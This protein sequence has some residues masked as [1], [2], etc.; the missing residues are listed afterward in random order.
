MEQNLL[1]YFALSYLFFRPLALP[2]VKTGVLYR[3]PADHLVDE[4]L[5]FVLQTP[6]RHAFV[7][8]QEQLQVVWGIL[9][10]FA[11]IVLAMAFVS[12]I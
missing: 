2:A 11:E 6:E 12:L 8:V 9:I 10:P 3:M 1:I 5:L 7:V 4:R